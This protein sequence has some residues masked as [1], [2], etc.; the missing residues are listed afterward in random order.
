M[1]VSSTLKMTISSGPSRAPSRTWPGLGE[2]DGVGEEVAEDLRQLPLVGRS[3]RGNVRGV[4]EE[5][6]STFESGMSSGRSIPRSAPKRPVSWT[7]S[8]RR[9]SRP[10]S[11]RARSS[12][13]LT[14]RAQLLGGP[15]DEAGLA[16]LL[17]RELAVGLVH[18]EP[19]EAEDRR[20]R[21]PKLVA[22]V[23]EEPGLHLAGPL[24]RLGLGVELQVERHDAPVGVGQ[25]AVEPDRLQL[26]E[27]EVVQGPEQLLVLANQ[28][29][30]RRWGGRAVPSPR[31]SGRRRSG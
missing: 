19:G 14:K 25:L 2:L 22:D 10:A 24:E 7:S 16:L 31:R 3:S 23:G 9:T 28:G 18:Q 15:E 30:D 29:V 6:S 11:I 21:R 13:S 17:D 26:A 8:N 5:I 20:Q 12:R 27:P 4:V 1:P